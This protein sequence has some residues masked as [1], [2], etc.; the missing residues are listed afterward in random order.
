MD[1]RD[2]I[3]SSAAGAAGAA[4]LSSL[5]VN[6]AKKSVKVISATR[7]L[8]NT[9]IRL[10]II[11]MGV[12]RSDNPNLVKAALESGVKY[13]D[14]AHGYMAG[15]N[16]EMLGR[17]L[18]EFPRDSFVL[19]TKV[20]AVGQGGG[21]SKK[22]DPSVKSLID[23]FDLSLQRLQ[24]DYVDI[25]FLHAISTR[26]TALYEPHMDAL[27]K[28]KK[29][30]K[31]RFVGVSTHSNEPEVIRAVADSGVY[32]AVLTGVNFHQDHYPDVK[33]AIA[34][35]TGKGI[36]I[37]GMKTMAGGFIDRERKIP[38]DPKPAIKFVLQDENVHTIIPGFTTFEQLE[39]TLSVLKDLEMHD[40]DFERLN[41]L[42]SQGSL[43]CNGCNQCRKQ[44]IKR[45]PIP[46]I[47][48]SYMYAYGYNHTKDAKHLIDTL[49]IDD[50]PCGSCEDCRISC[51]K[52][53]RI[54]EKIS[55]IIRLRN[56]PGDFL[57]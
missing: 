43:Y 1:R 31:A 56:I 38:V 16:E 48:R 6:A 3:K 28:L 20:K 52:N 2:F 24:M 32:D 54:R 25:L 51:P 5:P 4:F 30:G 18:K 23:N 15:R 44:C 22:D 8:G 42:K 9:G 46:D 55:D 19:S 35:A 53:F 11:S 7:V 12:M 45:L 36:G 37:V 47:M 14:T 26:E 39:V 34:Y 50:N 21:V 49:D 57:V 41:F 33:S 40:E 17:L 29:E 10:P 27:Q 13:L